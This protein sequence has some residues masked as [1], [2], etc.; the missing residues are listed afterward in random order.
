[1]NQIFSSPVLEPWN[2]RGEE[3]PWGIIHDFT[4]AAR[5]KAKL[6]KKEDNKGVE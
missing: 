6:K 2:R 5:G 1:M 4:L 3:K